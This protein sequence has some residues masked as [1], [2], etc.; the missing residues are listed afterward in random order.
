MTKMSTG[1]DATLGNYRKM[2]AAVFGEYSKPVKF[3]DDKIAASPDGANEEVI[4]DERQV[5]YMLGTMLDA[6]P[7]CAE[8]QLIGIRDSL[9][10]LGITGDSLF[11]RIRE[12]IERDLIRE[13][14]THL[15]FVDIIVNANGKAHGR[16]PVHP[17]VG[18]SGLEE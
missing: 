17:L 14:R 1:D 16:S 18:K 11:D 5:V 7:R 9:L 6:A 13:A 15:N 4:A 3:L 8:Q 10:T 2:A 12:D